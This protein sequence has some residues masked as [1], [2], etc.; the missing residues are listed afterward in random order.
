MRSKCASVLTKNKSNYPSFL[1]P[2]P[3]TELSTDR[4]LPQVHSHWLE[5]LGKTED[6]GGQMGREGIGKGIRVIYSIV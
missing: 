2:V 3:T 1:G 5:L 6:M 4:A